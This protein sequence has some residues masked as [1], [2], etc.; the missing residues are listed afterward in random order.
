MLYSYSRNEHQPITGRG[1][2][3][4]SR[5]N[6]TAQMISHEALKS[7]IAAQERELSKIARELHDDICQRLAML[8]LK[9]EKATKAWATG[10]E[11]VGEQLE[12]IWRQCSVLLETFK[13]CP[14]NCS[15]RF[16]ITWG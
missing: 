6:K 12:Q 4:K 10:Q 13:R 3:G 11:Q 7:L 16:S 14:T 5:N 1:E 15:R 2:N 8:P 9:I